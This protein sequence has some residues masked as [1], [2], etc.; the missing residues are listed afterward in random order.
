M[1]HFKNSA[2]IRFSRFP[3]RRIKNFK[4]T[5]KTLKV[6]NFFD[7]H[8][9]P[10]SKR[11]GTKAEGLKEIDSSI[12]KERLKLAKEVKEKSF[13]KYLNKNLNTIKTV[14]IENEYQGL[15]YGHTENYIKVYIAPQENI[16][17]GGFYKVKL[18]SAFKDGVIGEYIS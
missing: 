13:K 15:M 16:K 14:L 12:V 1:I 10:Y 7:I 18:I 3:P 8:I 2:I 6:A 11:I 5:L 4:E 17:V 9:F